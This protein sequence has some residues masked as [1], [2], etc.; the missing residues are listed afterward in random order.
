MAYKGV[1]LSIHW[2][3]SNNLS[4]MPSTLAQAADSTLI[5]KDIFKDEVEDIFGG[6]LTKLSVGRFELSLAEKAAHTGSNPARFSTLGCSFVY[7]KNSDPTTSYGG[8]LAALASNVQASDVRDFVI[9][10]LKMPD[11]SAPDE[12]IVGAFVK[13]A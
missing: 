6:Q 2:S 4:V 7:Y 9:A 5:D 8:Y 12:V 1:N 13:R 10:N 11:G 3:V